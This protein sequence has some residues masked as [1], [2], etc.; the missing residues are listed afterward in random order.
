MSTASLSRGESGMVVALTTHPT[1]A[2]VKERVELYLSFLSGTSWPVLWLTYF[3]P[4]TPELNPSAQ[5]C[6]T[7][8]FTGDFA[9]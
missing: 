4:L 6:L 5:R 3:N 8:F 9:S 2:E 7:R 1:N